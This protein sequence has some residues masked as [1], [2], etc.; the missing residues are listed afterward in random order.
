MKPKKTPFIKA[1]LP[2]Y[3]D[4]F[5]DSFTVKS[6]SLEEEAVYHR[7]LWAAWCDN[8]C[9][10]PAEE[11]ALRKISGGFI[12]DL[13]RLRSCWQLNEGDGRLYNERL[14]ELWH[15]AMEKSRKNTA[16]VMTR[17][18]TIVPTN[19]AT[20]DVT[21][22]LRDGLRTR[23]HS[24]SDSSSE[25]SSSSKTES[26]KKDT[27]LRKTKILRDGEFEEFWKVYPRKVGKKAALKAWRKA[28][29]RPAL[30]AILTSL[31]K[32]TSS[33]DWTKDGGQFIPYPAT[34]INQARWDDEPR[35][36]VQGECRAMVMKPGQRFPSPCNKPAI[37][38]PVTDIRPAKPYCQV[39][40]ERWA[41]VNLVAAGQ[42][43]GDV[44]S[45]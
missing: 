38:P 43:P 30:D 23:Y 39:C 8:R 29:D 32:A 34:W 35:A 27:L 1:W 2:W 11:G 18:A 45:C 17:Y 14:L 31:K 9:S 7:W 21:N 22:T 37:V 44:S 40:Y 12:G 19:V 42:Q 13:S 24:E 5:Y 3:G 26:K 16:A 28:E 41:K 36:A 6:M 20:N 4:D 33:V 10:L 25:Q 15:E